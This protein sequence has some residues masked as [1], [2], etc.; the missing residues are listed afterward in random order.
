[1]FRILGPTGKAKKYLSTGMLAVMW[2][3]AFAPIIKSSGGSVKVTRDNRVASRSSSSAD[4]KSSSK[5]DLAT[6]DR[7]A[8]AY[9]KIPLAFEINQGQ[10]DSPVEFISRGSG[11][12][13]FL[14]PREAIMFLRGQS[15]NDW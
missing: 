4:P 13:L 9:G 6:K 5:P 12:S 2:L 7:V 15:K 14:T 8:E 1:M 10:V 3:S 11:Y